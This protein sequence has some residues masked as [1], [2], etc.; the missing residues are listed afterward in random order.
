[1]TISKAKGLLGFIKRRAKDVNNVWV[2][3]Q[4]RSN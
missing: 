4:M 1:M 2:T 3:E